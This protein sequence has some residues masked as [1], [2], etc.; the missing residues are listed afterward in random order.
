MT[1]PTHT[2]IDPDEAKL[3]ELMLYVATQCES[4]V[5]F[6]ATKLN[7]VLYY[8]DFYAFRMRGKPLTG[9]AYQHLPMGPAPRILL[10]LKQ[11]MIASGAAVE[12][13]RQTPKGEQHRLVA[14][15]AADLRAFTADEI[16][17]V[18][19]VIQWLWGKSAE[20]V[21]GLS[22]LEVGWSLTRNG[23]DIPYESALIDPSPPS[24][25]ALAWARES[26]SSPGS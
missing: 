20:E 17:I 4:D 12:V 11:E 22:H 3:R 1:A 21:S 23:E 13:A 19:R 25:D 16:V 14:V 26:Y 15:R 9:V 2:T 6:G 7:K 10:R 8:S 5:A 24:A 18:D